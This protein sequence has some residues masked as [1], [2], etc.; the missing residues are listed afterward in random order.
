MVDAI[1]ELL[2]RHYLLNYDELKT[3][4][5]R[6]LGSVELASDV[7]QDT[8]LR[9]DKAAPGESVDHPRSYILRIARNL[10]LRS[11]ERAGR[12]LTLDDA[13]GA[14][15]LIDETPD[16]YQILEARAE[17]DL[18]KQAMQELTPRRRAI[19][20]A[21]RLEQVPL[22]DI[23]VRHGISQ[24][25]VERELKHALTHCAE[26]LGKKVTQRFGPRS[27]YVSDNET[28]A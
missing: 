9:L 21:S 7:L 15:D 16:P 23:A 3:R 17:F 26:R 11:Q 28:E 1:R 10:G 24:R 27:S 12:T 19:L 22:R 4:L 20:L 25:M 18:F 13:A 5:I 14:L 8:W 6:H 2:R